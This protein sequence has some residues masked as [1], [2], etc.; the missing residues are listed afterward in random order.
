MN[1]KF[2]LIGLIFLPHTYGSSP[3]L[4]LS[5]SVDTSEAKWGEV[6]KFQFK[7]TL[8]P[9]PEPD[10]VDLL[11]SFISQNRSVDP[12]HIYK[13]NISNPAT[14]TVGA[15]HGPYFTDMDYN[16]YVRNVQYKVHVNLEG[17]HTS[18]AASFDISIETLN[19]SRYRN[20]GDG[21]PRNMEAMV[22]LPNTSITFS[23]INSPLIGASYPRS[24]NYYRGSGNGWGSVEKSLKV[25][26]AKVLKYTI[27]TDAPSSWLTFEVSPMKDEMADMFHLGQMWF[28]LPGQEIPERNNLDAVEVTS[29]KSG[30]GRVSGLKVHKRMLFCPKATWGARW[31]VDIYLP[32]LALKPGE[33]ELKI[34]EYFYS[35]H[36][37][38]SSRY[39][40]CSGS[41]NLDLNIGSESMDYPAGAFSFSAEVITKTA[42]A[43]YSSLQVLVTATLGASQT[44]NLEYS[45]TIGNQLTLVGA[46]LEDVGNILPDPANPNNV[47]KGDKAAVELSGSAFTISFGKVVAPPPNDLTIKILVMLQVTEAA[48]VGWSPTFT[49]GSHTVNAAHLSVQSSDSASKP[50]SGLTAEYEDIGSWTHSFSTPRNS[51]K[52]MYRGFTQGV[53][54]K[55]TLPNS[56]L[57]SKGKIEFY[58]VVNLKSAFEV[59]PLEVGY[60]GSNLPCMAASSL[61]PQ[62][63]KSSAEGLYEDQGTISIPAVCSGPSA[64]SQDDNT[65]VVRVIYK[66]T[67]ACE[68][69]FMKWRGGADLLPGGVVIFLSETYAGYS[70]SSSYRAIK[71]F[72][73]NYLFTNNDGY[74]T[75]WVHPLTPSSNEVVE[76]SIFHTRLLMKFHPMNRGNIVTKVTQ[77]KPEGGFY[78]TMVC[79]I[80]VG[81]VGK[82]LLY[83]VR[84][85]PV[86]GED[87]SSEITYEKDRLDWDGSWTEKTH[88]V[89]HRITSWAKKGHTINRKGVVDDDTFELVF[90]FKI[91]DGASMDGN[92]TRIARMSYERIPTASFSYD[93]FASSKTYTYSVVPKEATA[94]VTSDAVVS[95]SPAKGAAIG[96]GPLASIYPGVP[97]IVPLVLTLPKTL[98]QKIT[99]KFIN[100]NF[101]SN[102]MVD[103]CSIHITRVGQNWP[104]L[105]KETTFTF[106]NSSDIVTDATTG[107]EFARF[108][109]MEID[110]AGHYA[111]SPLSEDDQLQ[112]ELTFRPTTETGTTVAI[113]AEVE[114]GGNIEKVDWSF[115]MNDIPQDLPS[116][117]EISVPDWKA[118][119][120]L[121]NNVEAGTR[122]W[123]P[124]QVRIPTSTTVP[125]QL[126]VLVESDKY[127]SS[128]AGVRAAATVEGFRQVWMN[129]N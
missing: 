67:G 121:R 57:A 84:P 11:L 86:L 77:V 111:Y 82:N 42:I 90:F 83:R 40:Y 21:Y 70:M 78:G 85:E 14:A 102:V 101:D 54:L 92:E 45:G 114:I 63:S 89:R 65:F 68:Y 31:Q 33:V 17:V 44:A 35:A 9:I 66:M 46:V 97:K 38:E 100:A 5:G 32:I 98:E 55:V 26:E 79:R 105:D 2:F 95:A 107:Q 48:P 47:A 29:T 41:C 34:Y 125:L 123:V 99:V 50:T 73:S 81:H 116:P 76:G 22:A 127:W 43:A 59:V 30:S 7:L 39:I 124:F 51:Y 49:V 118:K 20:D 18:A 52:K 10:K 110:P 106:S 61:T 113:T 69:C 64:A 60:V 88:Q 12:L 24:I 6:Q 96:F 36:N 62:M 112:L 56:F 109:S 25:N 16:S 27:E 15:T 94:D 93:N 115:H 128:R 37:Y 72:H 71:E 13:L 104:C 91:K 4:A 58:P 75:P 87:P 120:A 8:P 23:T 103:L 80:A 74:Y 126:A 19:P 1:G 108:L 122:V 3:S 129:L 28:D 119:G 53:G 117:G